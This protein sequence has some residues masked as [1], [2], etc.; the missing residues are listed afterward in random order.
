MVKNPPANAGDVCLIPGLGNPLEKEMVIQSNILP[1]KSH[2]QSGLVGYSP[3]GREESDTT[4]WL[5]NKTYIALTTRAGPTVTRL[6]TNI[7]GI[8]GTQFPALA[9]VEEPRSHK[10]RSY[11]HWG[12]VKE[13]KKQ[14]HKGKFGNFSVRTYYLFMLC[15]SEVFENYSWICLII[16]SGSRLKKFYFCWA[17]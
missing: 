5:N 10:P 13:K 16:F 17:E 14:R 3:W 4:E 8:P 1:G 9:L 15:T 7:Q 2:W 12:T 11:K 6:Q